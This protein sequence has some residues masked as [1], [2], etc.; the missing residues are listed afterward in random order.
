MH[1]L[2][3]VTFCTMICV[4]KIRA[5]LD[6][7]LLKFGLLTTGC[8]ASGQVANGLRLP[9]QRASWHLRV[10][11]E[12]LVRKAREGDASL[13]EQFPQLNPDWF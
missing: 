3:W 13:K 11:W 7:T 10:F 6:T 8:L 5:K 12:M 9:G 1:T 2:F 4:P